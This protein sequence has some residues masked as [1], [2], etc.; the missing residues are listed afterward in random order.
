MQ[1]LFT[2]IRKEFIHIVRDRRTL[3]MI[4]FMPGF[5]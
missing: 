5:L 3:I 4:T 2:I 1:R